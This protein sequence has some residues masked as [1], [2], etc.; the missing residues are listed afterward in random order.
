MRSIEIDKNPLLMKLATPLITARVV[1]SGGELSDSKIESLL[2]QV[3]RGE[4]SIEEIEDNVPF[5]MAAVD[6]IIG[7]TKKIKELQGQI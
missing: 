4:I 7:I 5:K 2:G 1:D 6:K 3:D